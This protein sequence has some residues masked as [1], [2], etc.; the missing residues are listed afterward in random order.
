MK[1]NKHSATKK[2]A[3]RYSVSIWYDDVDKCYIANVP[4]LKWCSSHGDTYAEAAA[5]V[6]ESMELWLETATR[7]GDPV[8]ASDLAMED[9]RRYRDVLNV[10]KLA[11]RAG[12]NKNTLASKLRRGS[13]FTEK[14][15]KAIRRALQTA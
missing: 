12:L 3:P 10:S 7:H 5:N 4:A 13:A 9:V 14:E 8:P 2:E 15:G 1:T 6:E 11:L